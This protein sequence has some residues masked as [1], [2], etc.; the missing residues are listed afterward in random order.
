MRDGAEQSSRMHLVESLSR[1][2]H[3]VGSDTVQSKEENKRAEE[4]K[5]SHRLRE[6]QQSSRMRK[7]AHSASIQRRSLWKIKNEQKRKRDKE[8]SSREV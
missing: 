8:R 3:S 5:E 4:K 6:Q 7:S 1:S 2:R